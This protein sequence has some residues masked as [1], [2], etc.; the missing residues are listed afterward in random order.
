M[1]DFIRPL[2]ADGDAAD[3]ASLR[4]AV[5]E[6]ERLQGVVQAAGR[7]LRDAQ[8][9]IAALLDERDA[10]RAAAAASRARRPRAGAADRR[11]TP[12]LALRATHLDREIA[13]AIAGGAQPGPRTPG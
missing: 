8:H 4:R 3:E 2:P 12:D 5:A 10:L 9:Q 7:A 11:A 6:I 1:P 13:D